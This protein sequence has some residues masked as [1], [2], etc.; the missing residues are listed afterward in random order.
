MLR[1]AGGKACVFQCFMQAKSELPNMQGALERT[2]DNQYHL[3]NV[4]GLG[5][6]LSELAR[7][8][9]MPPKMQTASMIANP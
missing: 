5:D 9:K 3:Y 7:V 4:D 6:H 8:C 2:A 1:K